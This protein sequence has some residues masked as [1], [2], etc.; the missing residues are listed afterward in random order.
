MKFNI[1]NITTQIVTL[2]T[3]FAFSFNGVSQNNPEFFEG[4]ILEQLN[5]NGEV[6]GTTYR[7]YAEISSGQLIAIWANENN[8]FALET[9]TSFYNEST[10]GGNFQSDINTAL[11]TTFPELQ[12]DTWIT[13][14][15]DFE[16]APSTIG[17]LNIDGINN[18]SWT[19]GGTLNSDASIYKITGDAACFP[20]SNGYVL[21]GQ[22]TTDGIIS[23][24]FNFELVPDD[25]G[26]V[27]AFASFPQ[28]PTIGCLDSTANNF[29]STCTI[30]N[31]A[32]Q[33][34][35]PSC[36]DDDTSVSGFGGCQAAVDL[37]GCSFSWA[38]APLSE[39]CPV[40]CDACPVYGCTDSS[41]CNYNQEA[42]VDDGSCSGSFD[43][44]ES[45]SG[46]GG[47]QAAVDLLGCS[48]SWAGA[49]LSETCPVSCDAC[50]AEAILGCTD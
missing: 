17:E 44:N 46:F 24:N 35:V 40:S 5:N 20:D 18:S 13:I 2:I 25:G 22:F 6:D 33:E 3:F 26:T 38:G 9:T 34:G 21:I 47:C 49:P 41:Y 8:P 36:E 10:V 32:C 31:G 42:I 12:W 14:G 43:N 48:F 37:L 28:E 45:V 19:F 27:S 30:D 23:G 4:L 1:R 39:T 7:L 16:N 29:C 11:Y 15:D 50:P